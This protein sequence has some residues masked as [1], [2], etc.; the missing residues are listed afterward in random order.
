MQ[1]LSEH[2]DSNKGLAAGSGSLPDAPSQPQID[3]P[4]TGDYRIDALL[5]G[6]DGQTGLGALDFRWNVGSPLGTP[7]TVTYSFMTVK[8]SYGGTDDADGDTGFSRFTAQQMTAARQILGQLQTE[9]GI[10]LVEVNDTAGSYG[11][12]R[13]GDNHQTSSA[14]YTWLPD[15]TRLGGDVWINQ[16]ITDN[17]NP[18]RGS[19]AW[20]T[21]VHEIGHALGLKHPGNYNA[22]TVSQP[23]PGNY[24]GTLEDNYNYTV[25]SYRDVT[26]GQ[27]RD[28]YGMYDLLTL[29][30]LYGSGN[31]GAGD[32]TYSYIDSD[33]GVLKIIDDASGYDTLDLSGVRFEGST[34]DMHPGGFSSFGR[35]GPVA[36]LKNL[37]I[38]L[39]TVIEK[40][41]GTSH[42]DS[43]TGND[44]AN[45]FVLGAGTNS[46]D[47]GAGIDKVV[48][49]GAR[50]GYQI[51]VSDG[52]VHISGA[53]AVDTL[54]SVER[55]DFADRKLAFDISGNA[56]IT[57]KVIGAVF[58]AGAVSAHPDYAGIG[59][60]L[61]DGGMS[62][63]S[64]AQYAIDA[65][66]GAAHTNGDVVTLLYTN[67]AGTAPPPSDYASYTS[68]L[69]S[70]AQ[71]QASLG[72]YAAEHELNVAHVDLVGLAQTG[73]VYA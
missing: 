45:L 40:F 11:Q 71:T 57:A 41:I 63:G 1:Y 31:L 49:T 59:L 37:S 10:T 44:A 55:V 2:P 42:D 33:G 50:F 18:V 17:L 14:G 23:A 13:F 22:G 53:N 36:A 72:V 34:V 51:S 73:L 20:S 12:I 52:A 35:N 6:A 66:L 28:W 4:Y 9:L 29:K 67:V 58:G 60:S 15:G 46:A 38:E 62:Y 48:Y 54:T 26:G 64:L 43:V 8:P 21:L 7:V 16:D 19:D 65:R 47:G 69:A 61:L 68:Q 24:L 27:V 5:Q 3:F 39:T 70:G 32:S 56:G 25:M 30:K